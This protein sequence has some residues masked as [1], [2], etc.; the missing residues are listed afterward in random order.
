MRK[1]TILTGLLIFTFIGIIFATTWFDTKVKCPVCKT[2]NT[3]K[4]IGSYGTYIYNWPEKFEYIYWPVTETFSMY[5]CSD[6]RYSAFMW[7]FD[8]ISGDTLE[9]IKSVI[10]TMQ[11][12]MKAKKDYTKIPMHE[13]METAEL[14]Y[15][16]YKTDNDFWCRFHRIKGYH[17]DLANKEKNAR[18][19]R[20]VALSIAEEMLVDTSNSYRKKEILL[21]SSTLCIC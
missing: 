14:F 3:F 10:D 21:N 1:K 2:K 4:Q 12:D 9:M 7:D 11:I 5:S 13:K 6:C 16:L 15:M 8:D 17:Y 20:M 18:E 19:S